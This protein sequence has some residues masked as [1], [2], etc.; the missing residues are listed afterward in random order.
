MGSP[1]SSARSRRWRSAGAL[2]HL[3]RVHESLA[4]QLARALGMEGQAESVTGGV[5]A[6]DDLATS[7]A[8]GLVAKAPKTIAGRKIGILVS[9]G[10]DAKLVASLR[11]RAE[12][13]DARIAVVAPVIGGVKARDGTLIPAQHT[14][15][16]APSVLFDAVVIAPSE[17]GIED[18]LKEAAAVDWLRD[19]FGHLKVI[20]LVPAARRLFDK[21]RVDPQADEDVVSLEG[22]GIDAFFAAARTHRIWQREP[23]VR[24]PR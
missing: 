6:R 11:E 23:T 19:A 9:E 15:S 13:E 21:A 24:T 1:S 12:A 16:S 8:L 3:E 10:V 7:P 17:V 22:K 14:L 5:P 20:G 4:E 2:G 18:L